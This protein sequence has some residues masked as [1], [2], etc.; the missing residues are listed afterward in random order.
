MLDLKAQMHPFFLEG[1]AN[2][3][4]SQISGQDLLGDDLF[5]L[6]PR[7]AVLDICRLSRQF[8]D[9]DGRSWFR[10]KVQF[11]PHI[12]AGGIGTS[13]DV[14]IDDCLLDLKT[15]VHPRLPQL[16]VDQLVVYLSLSYSSCA[17]IHEAN[18][19]LVRQAR[20]VTW[21]TEEFVARL[22][23]T[24]LVDLVTM[25]ERFRQVADARCRQRFTLRWEGSHSG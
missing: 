9:T 22:S 13:A 16:W 8:V 18:F 19:Y 14:L 20:S 7:T 6:I 5:G 21:R 2:V 15:T 3:R 17:S 4:A 10:R 1:H 11:D 24:Q 23:P 25:Q 12:S